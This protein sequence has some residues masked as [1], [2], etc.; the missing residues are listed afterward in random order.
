MVGKDEIY[1][2]KSG[3]FRWRLT[4]TSGRVIA[5]SGE[6]YTTKSSA[7]K[8]IWGALAVTSNR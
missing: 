7:I 3:K 6:S 4:R 5:K 8:D 1:K 2:D